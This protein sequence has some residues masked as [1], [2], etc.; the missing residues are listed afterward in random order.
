MPSDDP[1]VITI[2]IENFVMKKALIDHGSLIDTPSWKTK[3]KLRYNCKKKHG[4]VRKPIYGF[5]G[6]KVCTKGY[7]YSVP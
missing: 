6:E 5:S 1:M 2:D 7:I 4:V 3:K